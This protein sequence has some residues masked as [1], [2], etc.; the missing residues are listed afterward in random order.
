[1]GM[2]ISPVFPTPL[3]LI[4]ILGVGCVFAGLELSQPAAEKDSRAARAEELRVEAA[5]VDKAWS[6]VSRQSRGKGGDVL[7][8]DSTR[9]F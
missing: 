1:M 6:Q 2:Q 8:A 7:T 4:L 3:K 9:G 5:S